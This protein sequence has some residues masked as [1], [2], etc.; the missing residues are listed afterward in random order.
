MRQGLQRLGLVEA[1][2][3]AKCKVRTENVPFY[4]AYSNDLFKLNCFIELG[5]LQ[6]YAAGSVSGCCTLTLRHFC[7]CLTC[8][9]VCG[10]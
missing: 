7:L 1:S 2:G 10:G 9:S 4:C 8:L 6:S 5:S 3:L